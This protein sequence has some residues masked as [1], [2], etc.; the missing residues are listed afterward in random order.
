MARTLGCA[1]KVER[2]FINR[3]PPENTSFS[4]N[5]NEGV[6]GKAPN[7]YVCGSRNSGALVRWLMSGR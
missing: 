6:A 2:S 5:A 4:S 1:L 3:R 7:R